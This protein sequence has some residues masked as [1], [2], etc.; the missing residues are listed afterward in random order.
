MN[1]GTVTNFDGHATVRFERRLAASRREVWT[2]LTDSS[3]VSA[4][5]APASLELC[6]GGSVKIDFGE[7]QQ[8]NGTIS[9]WEP[10]DAIEYSWTFSGEPDSVLLIELADEEEGTA[11][12]LEHR[13]LPPDQA[14]GYGAGWHAHLDMLDAHVSGENPIDWDQRFSDVLGVYA[15]A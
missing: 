14:V 10:L 2:A 9:R 12:V 11:L 3:R 15:G 4:W 1:F 13:R 8:V 7:D 6:D 5:L